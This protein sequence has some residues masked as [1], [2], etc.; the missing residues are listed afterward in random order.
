MTRQTAT[1]S[2]E[3]LH[4]SHEK[5]S[6][7]PAAPLQCLSM[8]LLKLI[9]SGETQTSKDQP[10]EA[11]ESIKDFELVSNFQSGFQQ[12]LSRLERSRSG[13]AEELDPC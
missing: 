9:D 10:Q 2:T 8:E 6:V 1:V 11:S 4:G 12:R 3:D 7:N 5:A 13:K